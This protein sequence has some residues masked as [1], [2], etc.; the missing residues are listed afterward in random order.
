[1]VVGV[2]LYETN[3]YSHLG[4]WGIILSVFLAPRFFFGLYAMWEQID[5]LKTQL[6]IATIN[7]SAIK[8]ASRERKRIKQKK[9]LAGGK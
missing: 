3:T 1:M 4:R 8:A 6:D 2:A 5:D 9:Q 7:M